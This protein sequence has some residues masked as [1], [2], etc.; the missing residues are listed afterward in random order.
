MVGTIYSNGQESIC[1]RRN[2]RILCQV[3]FARSPLWV[4]WDKNGPFAET[5]CIP[6]PHW[7]I[8]FS[9]TSKLPGTFGLDTDL[10]E[11][12]LYLKCIIHLDT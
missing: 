10:E 6:S 9:A 7:Q 4:G 12:E 5:L 8:H 11:N 3:R 2:L 1:N